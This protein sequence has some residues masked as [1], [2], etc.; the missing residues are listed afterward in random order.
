MNEIFIKY[1]NYEVIDIFAEQ[2]IWNAWHY[3]RH[4]SRWCDITPY[5]II[6][7]RYPI[8][9]LLCR[10][11]ARYIAAVSENL[12]KNGILLND[13]RWQFAIDTT[14]ATYQ[15]CDISRGRSTG[16]LRHPSQ[17]WRSILHKLAIATKQRSS[18][19]IS[20]FYSK[21]RSDF[22]PGDSRLCQLPILR[23][24]AYLRDHGTVSK[25]W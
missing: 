2:S 20:R 16:Y 5:C 12:K 17:P 25:C 23:D 9:P 19:A 4:V 1:S 6:A 18:S 21:K 10:N 7:L 15:G 22:S 8:R 11:I 14:L 13:S 24:S 3:H